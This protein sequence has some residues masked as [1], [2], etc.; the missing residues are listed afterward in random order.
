MTKSQKTQKTQTI[1]FASPGTVP[2]H[3]ELTPISDTMDKL[4]SETMANMWDGYTSADLRYRLEGSKD[5]CKELQELRNLWADNVLQEACD[6]VFKD[7]TD[8]H[9][10]NL[11]RALL[12]QLRHK[13]FNPGVK[14]MYAELVEA[15]VIS[16]DFIGMQI[17]PVPAALAQVQ[18]SVLNTLDVASILPLYNTQ[19]HMDGYHCANETIGSKISKIFG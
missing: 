17:L 8:V 14:T 4:I 1:L 12:F 10:E 13:S 3:L 18:Q 2:Q 16:P 19:K 6:T 9:P 15:L 11:K 7:E 5:Y